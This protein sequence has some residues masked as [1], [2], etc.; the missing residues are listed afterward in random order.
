MWSL[1]PGYLAIAAWWNDRF[2]TLCADEIAQIVYII[3]Q[4][5]E[6]LLWM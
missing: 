2:A 5:G 3:G 1:G 4:L 6:N